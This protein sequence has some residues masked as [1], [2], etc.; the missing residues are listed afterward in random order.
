MSFSADSLIPLS[1]IGF[2]HN[3]D[4]FVVVVVDDHDPPIKT[5]R[6]WSDDD[7]VRMR[8]MTTVNMIRV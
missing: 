8:V 4:D 2:Q 7:D 5:W 3:H 6:Q 1:D